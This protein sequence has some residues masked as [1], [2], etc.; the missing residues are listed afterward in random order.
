MVFK[1]VFETFFY[2]NRIKNMTIEN[3]KKHLIF[4]S[5][6]GSFAYGT[7][8]EG[9]SDKDKVGVYIQP[10]DDIIGF[11]TYVPQVQDTKGD[12]VYYELNRFV[13]LLS[14]SNPTMLETLFFDN[15][16]IIYK[17]PVF[18]HLLEV[19]DKFV[20]KLCKNSF[21]GYA[22]Q[23]IT[24]ATGLDKKQN[25]EKDKITRKEPINFCY[26]I[27]G[28]NTT[29]LVNFLE[30]N[31]MDQKFCGV[32]NIAHARDMY[33][34]FYD[35]EAHNC[36]SEMISK[37]DREKNKAAQKNSGK[38]M[39]FGYKGIVK[40]ADGLSTSESNDLRLSSILKGEKH[41]AI[42]H[43]GKDS[44]TKH[45]KDYLEY[46]KWLK[47]RN[48][49]RWTETKEHGQKDEKNS[50]I[51]GKNMLH[52]KRLIDMSLEIAQGKGVIVRRPD[53]QELLKIRR[54]EVSLNKLL[55][56]NKDKLS[57]LDELFEKSSLP[58]DIDPTFMHNLVVKIRKEFYANKN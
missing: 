21:F 38:S 28:Y 14:V 37:E 20:T 48:V 15:D 17:H 7:Y 16:C 29:P 58:E 31:K 35:W 46:E 24:K 32:T 41:V 13:E 26:V 55:E 52:C 6:R 10:L 34:L 54:G 56:D 39:G 4:E 5:Y 43:Y 44:Y 51:D 57:K 18:D 25:W 2:K 45:C 30:K 3:V 49:N 50:M 22:K 33:A 19:R 8:I 12:C 47:A 11:K 36:F 53:A 23:Q 42:F 27:D 40:C 1:S 9:V